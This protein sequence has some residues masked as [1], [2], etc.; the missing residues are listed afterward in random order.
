[1]K[2][3]CIIPTRDRQEMVLHA[4]QSVMTQDAGPVE[5]V[6]VDDGSCDQ[7]AA[8]LTSRWP[9]IKVIRLDP[10]LGPGPARNAGADAASGEVLMF[11][12][13]DDIWLP[14]HVDA[15]AAVLNR[16]FKVAYGCTRTRD[17]IAG[18][19]FLIPE[20]G[21]E[22]EGDLFPA[23]ARWCFLLPSAVAMTKAA[24]YKTGGF[25]SGLLAEDWAFFLRLSARYPFGFADGPPITERRLHKQSI[26]AS[27]DAAMML[28]AFA[29]VKKVISET[30]RAKKADIGRLQRMEALINEEGKKWQTV[31]DWYLAAKQQGLLDK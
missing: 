26:C 8:A 15:L 19:E 4:V 24:F 20:S 6:V 21:M 1:M 28:A 31:Q 3:S 11:L 14:H 17:E 23:L 29:R 16:G 18:N 30:G 10:G 22:R 13:S 9:T 12:D 2:I 7:T 5:V 27:C 25:D